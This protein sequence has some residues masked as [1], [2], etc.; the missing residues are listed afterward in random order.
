MPSHL[1][2]VSLGVQVVKKFPAGHVFVVPG[3]LTRLS[4]D[5]VV[6]RTS[7]GGHLFIPFAERFLMS[8]Q[9]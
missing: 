4:A 3:G 8:D 1:T 5:V 7:M 9:Q 2:G 6:F